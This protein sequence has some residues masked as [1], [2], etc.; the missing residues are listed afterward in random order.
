MNKALIPFWDFWSFSVSDCDCCHNLITFFLKS[1]LWCCLVLPVRWLRC[2][3]FTVHLLRYATFN[4]QVAQS[5]SWQRQLGD[6]SMHAQW[7]PKSN[8]VM[9]VNSQQATLFPQS[10]PWM[11]RTASLTL[12][13]WFSVCKALS[14]LCTLYSIIPWYNELYRVNKA[15]RLR[16]Q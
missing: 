12:G 9:N 10:A 6:S 2:Q 1:K 15:L 4:N 11:Q 13:C 16:L 8:P 3:S 14:H 5:S 7:P